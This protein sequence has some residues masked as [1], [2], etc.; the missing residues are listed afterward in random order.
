MARPSKYESQVKPYIDKIK[1]WVESGATND[2]IA[3]ALG[4]NTSTLCAYKNKYKEF[5][6]AFTCGRKAVVCDIKAALL[7]KALGFQYEEKRQGIKPDKDGN[8]QTYTEIYTKYCPP[9]ETAAAMLLRNY[10]ERFRDQ[11]AATARLKQQEQNLRKKIAESNNWIE[12]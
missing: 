8:E 3:D 12:D 6:D 11:D 10:D 4:I 7:K 5:S 1:K 9:S 2:E